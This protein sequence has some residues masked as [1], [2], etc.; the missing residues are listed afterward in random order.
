MSANA[1]NHYITQFAQT[2]VL[3]TQQKD[4][5]L[6][7]CVMTGMHKGKKASP[8]DQVAAVSMQ[9]VA[10]R[11][12][13]INRVDADLKRRWVFPSD[14]DL[15]QLIDPFD[16][17]RQLLDPKSKYMENA[18]AAVNRRK[19]DT[20]ITAFFADAKTGEEAGTTTSF[21]SG[22]QIAANFGAASNVGMSVA[23]LRRARKILRAANVDPDEEFFCGVTAEEEEDLL[24]EYEFISRDFNEG[25]P[26]LQD[27]KLK[28][29][30]GFNFVHTERYAT[31]GSG[32][33]RCPA[34]VKSGMH[35]GLW[36]DTV[37]DLDKRKDL[38]GHPWQ[39]YV[40]LSLGAT[41]LE[42]EKVV[43]IICA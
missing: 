35:L 41:R 1:P 20:L 23:K 37:T 12:T 15:A 21:P 10:G 2:L 40:M 42:E 39:A 34:W 17:L 13:P 30:L 28:K 4:S 29:F 38:S 32:F 18:L 22:Q 8:V 31:N 5:R 7:P 43:E 19:D 11:F 26:V 27:G 9:P 36:M 14:Y 6:S 33:R 25:A 24:K 16:D 3:L